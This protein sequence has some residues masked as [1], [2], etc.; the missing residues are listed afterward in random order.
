MAY[1][2]NN[3]EI[4]TELGDHHI[5]VVDA[6]DIKRIKAS[7]L[8]VGGGGGSGPAVLQVLI[9]DVTKVAGEHWRAIAPAAGTITPANSVGKMGTNPSG[10]PNLKILK[11]GT[12]SGDIYL[13]ND[14][15]VVFS[16]G[17]ITVAANDVISIAGDDDAVAKNVAFMFKL[18]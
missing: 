2:L 17:T 11:N 7:D 6:G 4:I 9:R 18:A 1:S 14:G 15:S 16:F 8:G 3:A 5:V 13:N 12:I 10:A